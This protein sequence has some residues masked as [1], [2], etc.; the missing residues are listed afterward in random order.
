M[1]WGLFIYSV[2]LFSDTTTPPAWSRPALDALLA[3]N[4]DIGMDVI[5]IRLEMWNWGIGLK[6][7]FVGVR[8]RNFWA[9]FWVVV[10]F[11]ITLRL[12]RALLYGRTRKWLPPIGA[13]FG[14]I[15]GVLVTK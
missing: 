8:Y 10:S 15:A 1:G 13:I 11:S 4:I 2:C 14:G 5:S 6:E 7:E 3:L 12:L 9:W